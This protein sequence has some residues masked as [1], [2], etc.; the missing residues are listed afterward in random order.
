MKISLLR[1]LTNAEDGIRTHELLRDRT[2]E[3]APLKY[4][5]TCGTLY[6][7]QFPKNKW[8]WSGPNSRARTTILY[9]IAILRKDSS[10]AFLIITSL[11]ISRRYFGVNWKWKLLSPRLWLYLSNSI[12]DLRF[13]EAL[14]YPIV[15][16]WE[17][18]WRP[19]HILITESCSKTWVLINP[20]RLGVRCIDDISWHVVA[21]V[22]YIA[23][24]IRPYQS[25]FGKI[26]VD[27]KGY[28]SS[29]PSKGAGFSTP[30]PRAN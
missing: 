17:E 22:L 13:R 25:F 23:I 20:R 15:C 29:A 24:E 3:L 14:R 4:W 12:V 16:L 27:S 10:Q 11:N 28:D 5:A 8:T 21:P 30:W 19:S 9:F 26:V 1:N 6:F 2:L 18:F 7:L